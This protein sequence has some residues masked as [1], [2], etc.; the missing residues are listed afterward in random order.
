MILYNKGVLVLNFRD[1]GDSGNILFCLESRESEGLG[2]GPEWV[3]LAP[4]AGRTVLCGCISVQDKT[5]WAGALALR[6]YAEASG[7][8]RGLI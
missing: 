5:R 1:V 3:T 8:T 4:S 2:W 7:G 6:G